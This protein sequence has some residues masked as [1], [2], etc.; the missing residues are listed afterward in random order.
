VVEGLPSGFVGEMFPVVVMPI[1]VG[2][3]P[4]AVDVIAVG[5]VV[6]VDVVVM[7]VV[8]GMDVETV[9]ST[10]GDI[11]TGIGAI[12]GTGRGGSAGGCGA[13]MFVPG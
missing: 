2:M 5:D 4:N 11:G 1:G 7:A 3:V 13:G 8:P 10:V 9:L 12:E 6:V